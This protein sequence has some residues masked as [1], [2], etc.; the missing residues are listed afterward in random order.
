MDK[1]IPVARQEKERRSVLLG[2]SGSREV[3]LDSVHGDQR[4]AAFSDAKGDE[5]D[6]AKAPSPPRKGNAK[7]KGRDGKRRGKRGRTYSL[8]QPIRDFERR[9]IPGGRSAKELGVRWPDDIC[10]E[11]PVTKAHHF[12]ERTRV[13]SGFIFECKYCHELKWLPGT[14]EQAKQMGKLFRQYGPTEGYQKML[15]SRPRAR[16]ML[17]KMQDIRRLKKMLPADQFLIAVAAIVLDREY[18]YDAE[19]EEKDIL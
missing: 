4:P 15:N 3:R 6:Q 19:I 12:I 7:A 16:R 14:T 5:R 11:S 1:E 10:K 2:Y 18:P 17:S 9:N 8:G 13:D